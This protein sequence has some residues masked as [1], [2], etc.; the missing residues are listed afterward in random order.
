MITSNEADRVMPALMR[1]CES[2]SND[3]Q[4]TVRN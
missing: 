1:L 4:I 2:P 3:A